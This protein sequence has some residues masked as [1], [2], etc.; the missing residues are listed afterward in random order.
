[1]IKKRLKLLFVVLIILFIII[2]ILINIITQIKLNKFQKM[3]YEDMINYTLENNEQAKISIA[4]IKDGKI[5]YEVYESGYG[6]TDNINYEY[7]IGS[8]SKTF[9]GLMISKA[10]YENK[11]DVQDSINEYLDLEKDKY[12]PTIERL[13]THTSGYKGFYPSVKTTINQIKGENAFYDID[14]EKIF[15]IVSKTKLENKDY[16]FEYSNFGISVLGLVL[17][18]VY[19]KDYITLMNDFIKNDLKLYNT[20]VAKSKG[21][22]SD[23]MNWKQDDGYIPAGA[24]ISNINDM[25]EYLNMYLMKEELYITQTYEE[26]KQINANNKN[27]E[28]L[29]IRFDKIG[30]TWCIN[31]KNDI[32][33]HNGGTNNFNSYIGFN[34]KKNIGVIVLSNLKPSKD[35]SATIIGNKKLIMEAN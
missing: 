1:M 6:K 16:E 20:E 27:Y 21:N 30:F 14:K 13:L 7:E 28:K 26:L 31:D 15:K 23:Y 29:D 22:L 11:I 12:Y 3:N 9:V 34:K 5:E 8:I 4:I 17:E 25:A 32:I 10:E 35:I 2:N 33:W 18:K 19:N 24:I